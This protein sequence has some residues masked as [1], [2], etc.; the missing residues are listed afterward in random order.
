MLMDSIAWTGGLN[1]ASNGNFRPWSLDR[2]VEVEGVQALTMVTIHLTLKSQLPSSLASSVLRPSS[3]SVHSKSTRAYVAGRRRAVSKLP[4][5]RRRRRR[6][7]TFLVA[8]SSCFFSSSVFFFMNSFSDFTASMST[9]D[10]APR[11][12]L[13]KLHHARTST[14]HEMLKRC[15]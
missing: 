15:S 11:Y 5:S 7:R 13:I 10:G 6:R 1:L 4:S 8:S 2:F 9:D 14:F 12:C 3:C